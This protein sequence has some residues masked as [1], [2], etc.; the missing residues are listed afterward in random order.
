VASNVVDIL[1]EV[2][3]SRQEVMETIALVLLDDGDISANEYENI[4]H[5]IAM[6]AR[7]QRH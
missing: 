6:R 1:S 7:Q 2:F 4:L 3:G 5:E